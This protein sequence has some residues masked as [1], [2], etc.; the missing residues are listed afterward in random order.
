MKGW[1]ESGTGHFL[2][3]GMRWIIRALAA[4][5]GWI[6]ARSYPH[7]AREASQGSGHPVLKNVV[8]P[9]RIWETAVTKDI[10]FTRI[11]KHSVDQV[12]CVL[13]ITLRT[14]ADSSV[15]ATEEANDPQFLLNCPIPQVVP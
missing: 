1:N 14:P 9:A 15:D 7:A 2:S 11:T 13:I 3:R 5:A 10:K 8:G 12:V 6:L 4:R